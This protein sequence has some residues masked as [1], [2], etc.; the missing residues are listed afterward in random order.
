[1]LCISRG[2]R[3]EMEMEGISRALKLKASGKGICPNMTRRV[4]VCIHCSDILLVV[5]SFT[6]KNVMVG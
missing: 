5:P 1:L 6:S 4:L 3:Y 2:G